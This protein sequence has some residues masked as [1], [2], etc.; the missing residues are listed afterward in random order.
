MTQKPDEATAKDSGGVFESHPE[1]QF[2][3]VCVDVVNLGLKPEEFPGSEPRESPKT[4]MVFAS[5]QCQESGELIIITNEMTLS[6][7][8]KAN[9]RQFLESWRGRSYTPEQAEDGVPLHK[10]QGQVGLA[11]IEHKITKRGRKFAK[12]RSI[13]P[14]PD[15]MTAPIKEV[16]DEYVRPDFF[17]ERKK[18]YRALLDDFRAKQVK[19]DDSYD[20]MPEALDDDLDSSLPF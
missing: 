15:G 7:H 20:K 16:M 14:L 12:I 5:G 19:A 2:A 17:A 4:C 6:M 8:E 13:S 9:M 1:G 18:E 11:S 3:V 10:L